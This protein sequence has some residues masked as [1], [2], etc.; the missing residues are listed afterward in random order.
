M[1][2][3]HLTPGTEAWAQAWAE[4]ELRAGTKDGWQY[5]GQSAKVAGA[6]CFRLRAGMPGAGRDNRYE[7]IQP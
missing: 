1:P 4:L 7:H 2:Y 5:M 6:H 3:T